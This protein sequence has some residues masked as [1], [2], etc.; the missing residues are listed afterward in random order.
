MRGNDSLKELGSEFQKLLF[1][2]SKVSQGKVMT[3]VS[4]YSLGKTTMIVSFWEKKKMSIA[5]EL[6]RN[7][8]KK[9]FLCSQDRKYDSYSLMPYWMLVIWKILLVKG[10]LTVLTSQVIMQESEKDIIFE[11]CNYGIFDHLCI[12]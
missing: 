12:K 5:L 11:L 1:V 9:F 8:A 10:L 4:F 3:K 2:P 7:F 6:S